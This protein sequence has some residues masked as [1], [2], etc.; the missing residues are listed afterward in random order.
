M[1]P[2][3]G[4]HVGGVSDSLAGDPDL[5][6][7][8][9]SIA[10]LKRAMQ[11][12]GRVYRGGKSHL[13]DGDPCPLADHGKMIVLPDRKKQYCPDQSHDG[14]PKRVDP[15]RSFWPVQFFAAAVAAYTVLVGQPA[16]PTPLTPAAL[17]ELDMEGF[18]A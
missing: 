11:P 10:R 1:P 4:Q 18:D 12:A 7:A 13:G 17:P 15:T 8:R 6:L 16:A 9:S 2:S 5:E 14:V 3:S